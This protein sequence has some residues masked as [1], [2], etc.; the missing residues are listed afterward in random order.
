VAIEVHPGDP[1]CSVVFTTKDSYFEDYPD[2]FIASYVSRIAIEKG[3]PC[4]GGVLF[5][6]VKEQQAAP[7]DEYAGAL[8]AGIFQKPGRPKS[9]DVDVNINRIEDLDFD[10]Y[11]DMC[12]V[13]MLGANQ[14]TQRCWLFEP[15]TQTFERNE[16]LEEFI[17]LSVNRD[18]KTLTSHERVDATISQTSELA[19]ADGHLTILRSE[20]TTFYHRPDGK[21]L[22]PGFTRYVERWERGRGNRVK[23]FEGPVR[24]R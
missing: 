3:G 20:T 22:P 18:K 24:D 19:W 13:R 17:W 2:H 7:A 23:V 5:D 14:Y 21:A 8:Q 10:G 11:N 1:P 6:G 4:A 12:V 16:D 15:K 9:P